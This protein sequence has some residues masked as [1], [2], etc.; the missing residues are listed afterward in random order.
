MIRSLSSR[1]RSRGIVGPAL[2]W[3]GPDPFVATLRK[4]VISKSL[5]PSPGPGPGHGLDP[6]R[7]LARQTGNIVDAATG[8]RCRLF[9]RIEAPLQQ[10]FNVQ[11]RAD[12]PRA[13][14]WLCC[15]LPRRLSILRGCLVTRKLKCRI[16][17]HPPTC[18]HHQHR[19]S[20][21]VFTSTSCQRDTDLT[22][23]HSA[24][25]SRTR[26]CSSEPDATPPALDRQSVAS[27]DVH[28]A[29]RDVRGTRPRVCNAFPHVLNIALQSATCKTCR[30]TCTF[31]MAPTADP[32]P[33]PPS[34]PFPKGSCA[35]LPLVRATFQSLARWASACAPSRRGDFPETCRR[36]AQRVGLAKAE[37]S[38]LPTAMFVSRG[39]EET[40]GES[41]LAGWSGP[42]GT[43]ARNKDVVVVVVEV[44]G[45]R[46]QHLVPQPPRCFS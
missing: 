26:D 4:F 7:R 42:S 8:P 30:S 5:V 34:P 15:T 36:R 18:Q 29:S 44:T 11:S 32:L 23:W 14:G 37:A 38:S 17:S 41:K 9:A 25:S 43:R 6:L 3:N 24:P 2:V 19:C 21:I 1:L 40:E 13:L 46:N 20:S 10:C 22:T 12:A 35:A 39:L 45:T 16:R 27:S 28:V 31:P 33:S